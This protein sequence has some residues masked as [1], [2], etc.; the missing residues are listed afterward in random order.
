MNTMNSMFPDVFRNLSVKN[1][2]TIS[3][4]PEEKRSKR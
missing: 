3:E 4:P 2:K 1:L